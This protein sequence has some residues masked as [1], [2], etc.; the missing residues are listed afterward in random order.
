MSELQIGFALLVVTFVVLFS[1]VPI[2][3]G[4]TGVAVAFLAVFVG[5][6]G[7]AAVGNTFIGE[8]S[9]FALLTLPMFIVLGAAI[10]LS[11][12]SKDIYESV[13]HWL[14][15]VPGGLVIANIIA[16][17]LFSAMCGSSPA[18]AA[19]IGKAGIPE[20]LKRGTPARL[21][22]GSI[23]AGGSLG[24]L[25][26]PSITFI[27]YGIAT[28]TSIGRLFL[29]GVVPGIM[30]VIFFSLYA[31]FVSARMTK[32][33]VAKEYFSL[34]DKFGGLLRVLPFLGLVCAVT[35]FM[36]GGFATPS[37]V[38]AIAALLALVLVIVVYRPV[39]L[40]DLWSI[41]RDATRDSTMIL[42]IVAASALY[43][44]MMSYLYITQSVADWM[45]GWH[46]NMWQLLLVLNLFLLLA[47][48]FMP[49]VA[50]I[51][52]SMP[53]ILPVL[54]Q[55]DIDLVWFGV[56]LTIN[57]E[58]GLIHPPVGLNLFVIRGIAPQVPMRD[59]MFG[60]LP[61][62]V[63]MMLFIVLLTVFPKIATWL[64]DILMGPAR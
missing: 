27:I 6:A 60:A 37:E 64:P 30:L 7:L 12:A 13:H 45:F 10:G 15:R 19:A 47:G 62:V 39:K 48:F 17:G 2:A 44:Y 53:F 1:G 32:A 52:M 55:N 54:N 5:A 63:I 56:I 34:S 29:A 11:R 49:A 20:M 50:I 9:N 43:S 18:T 31:W 58:I 23:A 3:F 8:L 24:I 40:L 59:V 33:Q 4:L 51:L 14:Y 61:F 41:M 16:C 42:M 28:E 25:I 26:P 21:A 46:L 38:A 57:C 22:T 36:Y 35:A